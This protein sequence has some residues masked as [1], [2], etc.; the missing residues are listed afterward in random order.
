MNSFHST[1]HAI[2]LNGA[3]RSEVTE[4]LGAEKPV[5]GLRLLLEL[6]VKIHV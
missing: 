6:G 2:T 4:L 3:S 5:V 1:T